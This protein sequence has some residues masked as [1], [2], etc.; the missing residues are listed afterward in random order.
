L[1]PSTVRGAV[2]RWLLEWE[3]D[4]GAATVTLT[5]DLD[6]L[7]WY[8][9][10]NVSIVLLPSPD[11]WAS[12]AYVGGHAWTIRTLICARRWH[13][14]FGAEPAANWATVQQLVVPR[15]P[16]DVWTAWELAREISLLWPDTAG[17]LNGV[18][19]RDHA[20]DLVGRSDWFLHDKP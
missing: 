5:G 15:P 1:G 2:E 19:T 17:G 8:T 20:R 14:R 7:G 11:P 13:E 4:Q 9:P 6:Y 12:Y 16:T 18:D 3:I 10:D